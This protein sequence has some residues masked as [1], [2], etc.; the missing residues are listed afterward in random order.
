MN[1]TGQTVYSEEVK[2]TNAILNLKGLAK[3]VYFLQLRED[4]KTIKTS[5]IIIQ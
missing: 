2:D 1:V 4:N 3:G 5:R